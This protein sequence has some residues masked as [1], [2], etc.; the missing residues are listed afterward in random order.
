MKIGENF[1][2]RVER[3]LVFKDVGVLGSFG[4]IFFGFEVGIGGC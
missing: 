1:T 3:E 4:F 2:L